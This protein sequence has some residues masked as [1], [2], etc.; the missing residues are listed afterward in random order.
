MLNDLKTRARIRKT[1]IFLNIGLGI[2]VSWLLVYWFSV[3]RPEHINLATSQRQYGYYNINNLPFN[4]GEVENNY[5]GKTPG[6]IHNG[7]SSDSSE[8][9]S[10]GVGEDLSNLSQEELLRRSEI[11]LSKTNEL[12]SENSV[13]EKV[14]SKNES[15]AHSN[16]AQSS[17]VLGHNKHPKIAF[18]V[19]NLGLNRRSTELA[20]TLPPEC[21]LGFLPYTKTLKPLLNKAQSNGHEVYIYLPLQTAKDGE[22]PGKYALTGDLAPE[23]ITIRLNVI[24]NAQSKFNGVYSSYK[25]VFTDNVQA[26]SI[27]LDQIEDRNL[28]FIMGKGKTN[29]VAKHFETHGKIIIPADL[30]LDE[31]ADK[32]AINAKM[33][34]LVKLAETN[35]LAVGYSQG[36]TLTIEI[37]RDWLPIIKKRGIIVTPISTILE[38]HKE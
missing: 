2:L 19:T 21:A 31:E 4:N 6:V 26:S 27:V 5:F 34:E 11:L 33:E 24:L 23:D 38:G 16:K 36:F 29:K 12:M 7:G 30:V 13:A 35:G 32:K 25:E 9:I 10:G 22:N 37:I 15:N 20:L 28:L 8:L 17:D 1:L 14:V 18:L 3:V